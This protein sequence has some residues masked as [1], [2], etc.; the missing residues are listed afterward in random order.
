MT[1]RG[2][3]GEPKLHE[4]NERSPRCE[5]GNRVSQSEDVEMDEEEQACD[6]EADEN[7]G[8]QDGR[9][10]Q[11]QKETMLQGGG[12]SLLRR[13]CRQRNASAELHRAVLTRCSNSE[14]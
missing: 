10:V 2:N 11:P 6:A 9:H 3:V 12:E 13:R 4:Q 14:R 1:S 8:G 5:H 7:R